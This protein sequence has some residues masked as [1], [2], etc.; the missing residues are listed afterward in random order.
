[1]KKVTNNKSSKKKAVKNEAIEVKVIEIETTTGKKRENES[2]FKQSRWVKVHE[3]GQSDYEANNNVMD[4]SIEENSYRAEITY[5]TALVRNFDKAV[6]WFLRSLTNAKADL[7]AQLAT[8]ELNNQVA[9]ANKETR[10]ITA[11]GNGWNCVVKI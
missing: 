9:N 3:Q 6:Y 4:I 5:K 10:E 1:M 8:S 7:V 2:V 11:S